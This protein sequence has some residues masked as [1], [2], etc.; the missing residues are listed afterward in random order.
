M[1]F[2]QGSQ[3]CKIT[4]ARPV[5]TSLQIQKNITKVNILNKFQ[6]LFTTNQIF[7][8]L[9]QIRYKDEL[10]WVFLLPTLRHKE[11]AWNIFKKNDSIHD[12]VLHP[13]NFINFSN[14]H[15]T[16]SCHHYQ[17]LLII[18]FWRRPTTSLLLRF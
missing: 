2:H 3:P 14:N 1:L 6:T 10:S 18:C 12:S 11:S 15:S 5:N 9:A 7:V 16:L 4:H 17:R 8:G 13:F